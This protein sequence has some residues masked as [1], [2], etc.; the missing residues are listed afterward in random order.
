MLFHLFSFSKRKSGKKLNAAESRL[1]WLGLTI[2]PIIWAF[3]LVAAIFSLKI[4]WLVSVYILLRFASFDCMVFF[5]KSDQGKFV[6]KFG[7]N[8]YVY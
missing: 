1:F 3:L 4:K 6:Y 8:L 7:G 2:C 5:L